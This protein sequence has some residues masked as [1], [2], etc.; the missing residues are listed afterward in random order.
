LDKLRDAW[1]RAKRQRNKSRGL[2]AT[3][4]VGTIANVLITLRSMAELHLAQDVTAA[5]TATPNLPGLGREDL[6][7]AME[8]A[9]MKLLRSYNYF[10]DVDE[11][12]AAYA[13]LGN[14]L[15]QY[16]EDIQ[17]CEDEGRDMPYYRV[18]SISFTQL[19]LSLKMSSCGSPALCSVYISEDDFDL[20]LRFKNSYGPEWS[21][22]TAVRRSIRRFA[23][24]Q[25]GIDKLQ[26][27]GEAASNENFLEALRSALRDLEPR[28]EVAIGGSGRLE[29]LSLAARGA[30]ELAKRFQVMTWNCVEPRRCNETETLGGPIGDL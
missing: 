12:S 13:A 16:P 14:G 23:E 17:S 2:P 8:Y 1:K 20:G 9:R 3:E 27:C 6:E 11:V 25:S 21:Y 10:G 19:L 28:T 15:C 30:A 5:V 29:P 4:D 7:D 18:L 24:L 26:L 22:W